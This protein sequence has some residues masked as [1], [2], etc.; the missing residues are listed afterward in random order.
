MPYKDLRDFIDRL[1]KEGELWEI[2]AEVDPH[3]ELGA[4]CRKTL[5]E[6]SPA[7][8]FKN[9]KGYSRPVF[10]NMLGTRRRLA[11]AMETP[12][13]NLLKKYVER[14]S[15]SLAIP[16]PLVADGPCKEVKVALGS[17]DLKQLI[18]Q[19]LSN[20]DDGGPFI[21]Y[22]LVICKDPDTGIR[23][24]GIYRFQMREGKT[25]TGL[26]SRQPQHLAVIL[27]KYGAMNKP[28]EI[29]IAI[30][31][32]PLLYI[33]SQVRE[34]PLDTDEIALASA[35]KGEPVELVK[36]ET[37]DLM[38]PAT[39][40]IVIEGEIRPHER[41]EEGPFGEFTGFRTTE[42]GGR[43]LHRIKA[44]THR[45]NPI[46]SMSC[47]GMPCDEYA[48]LVS[49]TLSGEMLQILRQNGIPVR[50]VCVHPWGNTLSTIVSTKV[51][52]AN[53]AHQIS[54]M[55]WGSKAG[56]YVHW[57]IVVDEN[58]DP[59]NLED[60]FH[61]V[62]F[63]CNPQDGIHVYKR[64]LGMTLDPFLTPHDRAYG[65]GKSALL[66]ATFPWEWE[67]KPIR[68]TIDNPQIYPEHIQQKVKGL[69]VKEYGYKEKY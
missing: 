21:N 25:R 54:S 60:V 47:M 38:V 48:A 65:L 6:K 40:E 55:I 43:P 14:T 56:V 62:V 67:M 27:S 15:V 8:L 46:L 22:G 42:R 52:Y 34:L 50:G 30:G 10:A 17:F 7:L 11:L 41:V 26:W 59:W 49:V 53:V 32:D 13:E 61:A 37:N 9:V 2:E 63:Q 28:M 16:T 35:M 31:A 69:W 51:P 33:A 19:I 5:N 44:I 23:N 3:L 45:N 36:C 1:K 18:P 66:D 12:E 29:A 68:V 58:V 64:T 24:M 20:P 57:I 4:I 39:S